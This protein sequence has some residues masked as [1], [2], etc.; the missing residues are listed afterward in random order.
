MPVDCILLNGHNLTC[1]ES[2]ATGE[3]DLI[4]KGHVED[5]M[6]PFILSGT[7]VFDGTGTCVAIAVG[8]YYI[9]SISYYIINI[10]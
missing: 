8:K 3:S 9:L 2:H 10:K 1:D 6:D 4:K 7:E 5:G